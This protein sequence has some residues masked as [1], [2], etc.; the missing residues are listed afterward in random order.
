M[1]T[2]TIAVD[3][4][5]A[6]L[7]A[8]REEL[9]ERATDVAAGSDQREYW[10]Q[11]GRRTERMLDGLRWLRRDHDTDEI[12]L[13]GLNAGE[14]AR[15]ED[16]VDGDETGK[17]RILTVCLGTETAPWAV[18]DVDALADDQRRA[19]ADLPRGLVEWLESRISTLSDPGEGNGQS[20]D[21]LVASKT[22]DS[23][24]SDDAPPDATP[25]TSRPN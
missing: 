21:E 10:T 5:I 8:E 15:L 17:K 19:V 24:R 18:D 14:A 12:T 7:E 13:T 23:T 1:N 20:F 3:D 11:L 9:A 22:S 25:T 6:D 4:A 16:A 2:E